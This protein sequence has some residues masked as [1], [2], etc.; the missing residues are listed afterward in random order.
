MSIVAH[1]REKDVTLENA[2]I[3]AVTALSGTIVALW[4]FYN[5]REDKIHDIHAAEREKLRGELL[6]TRREFTSLLID[7]SGIGQEGGTPSDPAGS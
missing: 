7:L 4:R 3:V 2:L 5:A 6:E 1:R